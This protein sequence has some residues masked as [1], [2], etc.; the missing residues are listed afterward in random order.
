MLMAACKVSMAPV[1]IVVS[2][3]RAIALMI[4]WMTPRKYS[5]EMVALKNT[6]IGITYRKEKIFKK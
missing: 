5:K 1:A 4:T 3:T 6:I 2:I